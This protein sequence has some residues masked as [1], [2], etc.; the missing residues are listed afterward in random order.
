MALNIL[1][2]DQNVFSKSV[3]IIEQEINNT[4]IVISDDTEDKKIN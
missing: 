2:I 1:D 3:V 4:G